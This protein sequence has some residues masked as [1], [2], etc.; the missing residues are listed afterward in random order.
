MGRKNRAAARVRQ[1]AAA[2]Q[3]SPETQRENA[4]C[5]ELEGKS[6]R[7]RQALH[8]SEPSR[9]VANGRRAWRGSSSTR[10]QGAATQGSE[11]PCA[12]TA[13]N[14]ATPFHWALLAFAALMA[15]SLATAAALPRGAQ[16]ESQPG[17]TA[18]V[19]IEVEGYTATLPTLESGTDFTLG[20]PVGTNPVFMADAS[21]KQPLA[22]LVESKE[23]LGLTLKWHDE[24]GNEFDWLATPVTENITVRGTF[25]EADYE[26]RVS[27][28]DEKTQDLAVS[29]PRGNSF[30]QAYG[31]V[32]AT[33]EKQGWE[34]VRWVDTS[35]N[36][37]FDFAKPVT[38]S[39]SV[40]A[41][42]KVADTSKVEPFDPTKD[43]PKTLTGR[44]YIGATWSVHPAQF[45]VSGFTGGL[46]GYAGTG[47]C[48]L[49]SAAAPSNTWADYVATLKEVNVEAG[50]VVYDVNITPPDAASPDG[51][52]NSLG[53]IGYQTV[54]L[55]AVI[56]KNF[57]GYLEVRKTSSNPAMSEGNRCYSLEDAVF[58]VYNQ[59]GSRVA[60]LKTSA[61]GTTATSPL[62]PAGTYTIR[63]EQ[64]PK[65]FAP[66]SDVR[67]TVTSGNTTTASVSDAP[68]NTL[69]SL[70]GQKIDE[71]TQTPYP[72]GSATLEGALFKVSY[73]DQGY[74][75]S[76][77]LSS[78]LGKLGT[79]QS[80][81]ETP[82]QGIEGLG[83]PKRTWTFKTDEAGKIA[84]DQNHLVEGDEFY[85][86]TNHAVA[87][88]LGTVVVEETQAPTGYLLNAV[89]W[90]VSLTAEGAEEHLESW[91][92]LNLNE[93]VIRGDLAFTKAKSGTM[94]HLAHV[95]FRITSRTTGEEHTLVTDEN[96]MAN[97]ASSWVPHSRNTN[98]GTSAKDGLWFAQDAQGTVAK[99][100]DSLGALPYDT[101]DVEELP[102]AENEG[103]VL[104]RFTVTISRN[105]TT[106][107]LG[108]IDNDRVALSISGEVD[109]QETLI[110]ETGAFAYTV[111][112]RS[113][114]NT[115]VDEF[116]M[117]DTIT[118]A[119]EGQA[120]LV[121]VETPVSF[122][123]YDGLMNVWYRTNL[124]AEAADED[125]AE[126]APSEGNGQKPETDGTTAADEGN[127][128]KADSETS[129]SKDDADN[130]ETN[131]QQ[132][133]SPNA[134]ASNP[135]NA[136]NPANQ[137]IHDFSGWR[138]WKE[139]VSTL[140]SQELTV[141]DLHLE[142]G[143]YVTGVAFEHG[144][145]EEGF[146]TNAPD[147]AQWERPE[148][149]H[150]ADLAD[151]NNLAEGHATFNLAQATGPTHT[152]EDA[153][154][155]YAPAVLHMQ[156]TDETLAKDGEKLWNT[157]VI[158]THRDLELH[159]KDRDSVVQSTTVTETV[160]KAVAAKLPKTNDVA[161]LAPWLALLAVATALAA[162]L[163]P[164]AQRRKELRAAI[165][166]N[167]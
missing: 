44:C 106:L 80:Q 34:F 129:G 55:K 84:F 101:Y 60:E 167:L 33:P 73:Y 70:V 135:F 4:C 61:D 35:D 153:E 47:S 43:I 14:R 140:E 67:A 159:D 26:V 56:K 21:G 19:T 151:S 97:T 71:E 6:E 57:G 45:A 36:S 53:L 98:A 50:E 74:E 3:A 79:N 37:T 130:T 111:D 124:S 120:N 114:S 131:G 82:L 139:G 92:P 27:F 103:T 2:A 9:R 89:P 110:D 83:Q 155:A 65:G 112:Y 76:Q 100:D 40:Y 137:R 119:E 109:K 117:T 121:S 12:Q 166:S 46:E 127:V 7:P 10:H 146:G 72:M 126:T 160:A 99:V 28:N 69:I 163:L 147:A 128:A 95:P 132:T 81:Q 77:A 5:K 93:Q 78:V 86:D 64:A 145:V 123:D 24:K 104:A 157:A 42:F 17:K 87:L 90:V 107:D 1:S 63:E 23:A 20:K 94:E 58:G 149:Y 41:L 142:Q 138:L 8:R 31:S 148:R 144:R 125:T 51:P 16:A 133:S 154:T 68:Q 161:I 141:A 165:L 88:P 54:Y 25:V 102:C 13:L 29:V 32:P 18:T 75:A 48:S 162:T 143:E 22:T 158:D 113:T 38:K 91:K 115:W 136:N 150:E 39:T 66:A 11:R 96:G 156:A 152:E 15:L 105:N 30:K 134:S 85:Y 118:C 108:T 59:E 62:L 52:R 116:A 164:R 122:E 49:P